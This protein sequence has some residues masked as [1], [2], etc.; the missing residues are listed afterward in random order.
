[1]V[2]AAD[3]QAVELGGRLKRG[4]GR[5]DRHQVEITHLDPLHT[6][7]GRRLVL[8]DHGDAHRA[9][10]GKV[11]VEGAGGPLGGEG[12]Q[13]LGQVRRQRPM[14]RT[15]AHRYA[16]EEHRPAFLG[17]AADTPGGDLRRRWHDHLDAAFD[18]RPRIEQKDV[19]CFRADAD[20]QNAHRPW[21][22]LNNR[23][24]HS[25]YHRGRTASSPP[26]AP[27]G[28]SRGRE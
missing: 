11:I 10:H 8:G 14:A 17:R 28:R 13:V 3:G 27:S 25:V 1:V 19:L 26:E 12:A 15:A 5:A 24:R 18:G 21:P 7:Q 9:H 2:E 23:F 20:G 6:T 22:S 16:G 4:Q